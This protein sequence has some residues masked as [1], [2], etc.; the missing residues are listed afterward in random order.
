MNNKLLLGLLVFLIAIMPVIY[1]ETI[2]DSIQ[3]Q[4][5]ANSGPNAQISQDYAGKSLEYL[6]ETNPEFKLAFR[7]VVILL[8]IV[9][10]LSIADFVLRGFAMW[11]ACKSDSKVWFWFLLIVNSL[12]ILPIIY[13]IISRKSKKTK[14]K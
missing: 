1:A 4:I 12:C 11:R 8:I 13:L 3:Q 6:L 5:T 10:L 14:K 7:A 9:I 2:S